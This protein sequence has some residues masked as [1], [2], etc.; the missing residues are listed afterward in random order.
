M[1]FYFTGIQHTHG[2][3]EAPAQE[4]A[5]PT[6]VY[7]TVDDYLAKFYQE[8]NYALSAP[9]VLDGL[10]LLVYNSTGVIV[11]SDHWMRTIDGQP[12]AIPPIE[13]TE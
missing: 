10:T 12:V 1:K 13:G 5:I 2:T 4:I 8:M 3:E 7:D 6:L 9:D 11:K